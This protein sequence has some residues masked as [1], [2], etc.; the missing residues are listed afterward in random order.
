M[1]TTQKVII[2]ILVIAILGVGY[3]L[4][5]GA[6]M[7]TSN[8]IVSNSPTPTP[9]S[10]TPNTNN[11][12]TVGSKA[13]GQDFKVLSGGISSDASPDLVKIYSDKVAA[14]AVSSDVLDVSSCD[15]KPNIF[16]FELGKTVKIKNSDNVPH[17]LEFGPQNKIIKLYTAPANS[18]TEGVLAVTGAGI[19]GYRCDGNGPR[20][21]LFI[22]AV[23]NK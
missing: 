14:V 12:Q 11:V 4:Y 1:Q 8:P 10:P 20:G 22:D 21:L 16:R 6:V 17:V 13:S 23:K 18:V 5:S 3:L 15:P 7:P 2:S 9:A 19:V